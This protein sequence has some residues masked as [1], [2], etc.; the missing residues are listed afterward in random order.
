MRPKTALTLG[1]L[2]AFAVAGCGKSDGSD[3]IAT[4]GD[5]KRPAAASATPDGLTDQ[6]RML[7]YAQCMRDNGVPNFPDPEVS[8]EGAVRMALPE[9]TD[10]E[11]V[12]AAQ[13]KCKQYLPNGGEPMKAD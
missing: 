4:A 8:D 1:L 6:E 11:K 5:G 13:Q 7:K 3:G 2:L 10:P 12:D 9:G